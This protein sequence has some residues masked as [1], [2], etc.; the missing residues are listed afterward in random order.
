[1]NRRTL[2]VIG[3]TATIT[4]LASAAVQG[5]AFAARPDKTD[6]QDTVS[7][8][9]MVDDRPTALSTKR[10]EMKKRAMELVAKGERNVENRGGSKSVR[11][12]PGQWVEYETQKTGQ[13]LSFL[14]DFNKAKGDDGEA[15]PVHGNIPKPDRTPGDSTYDNS[16][17]W[18]DSFDRQH[19]LDMFFNGMPEQNGESFHDAYEELSS[20]RYNI[21][22][23]VSDWVTVPH[24]EAYYGT[25]EN[26]QNMTEFIS[27]AAAAWLADA[28]SKG[29]DPQEYLAQFDKW[30]RYDADGD[31]DFD[32]PDGYIDHFQAIHA[33]EGEEAGAPV[34]AIWS[35]RWA[36][37][38]SGDVGPA[39][40][41]LGGIE[42]GDTGFWIRDYTTE[43]ENGG[44]GVFAHEFGHDLGLPDLYDTSGGDNGT[45]F[46]TLMSSGSWMNHGGDSIGTTPNHMGAWEKWFLGWLDYDVAFAGES[47]THEI[48]PA[49][50]ATKKPQALIT[51]LP[52]H[53]VVTE[54]GPAIEGNNYFY[55]G[56]GDDRTATMT[57][58]TFTVPDNGQLT[59]KVNYSIEADWDYAYAEVSTDGETFTPLDTNLSTE[60][61]P[62]NQNDGHGITGS[63]HGEWVDLVADMAQYAGQDVQLRFRM[64]NDAGYNEMGLKVDQI[65]VGDALT[66]GAEDGA[67][68][69][70]M[71]K[72]VV[73]EDGRTEASYAGY[74]IA[75]SRH[76]IGYDAT[77]GQGAYNFG[78]GGTQPNR[79]ER[80]PYQDGLLISYWNTEYADNNTAQHP[81]GG[82]VLPVDARPAAL[83]WDDPSSTVARSR[84]QSFDV[85][86]GTQRTD[87]I[88]LHR[89]YGV[90]TNGDEEADEIRMSNLHVG[91]QPAVRVFDDSDPMAY[92]DQD[93]PQG[94]VIVQGTGTTITVVDE[95][96]NNGMMTL[97]VN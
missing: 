84:I 62:N 12:A 87:E 8:K 75:E 22:G 27:D 57:S 37:N 74:Y 49:E 65:A 29:L 89:E 71:D 2:G 59:A 60:T 88:S 58:P 24:N 64:F 14:V 90:D 1:V 26:N 5:T 92:Y 86:F 11:I 46:W 44:L 68:D 32:E 54:L 40:A 66:E 4:L 25:E 3:G 38:P 51:I 7:A 47:S 52:K 35:H 48:G 96:H 15:G 42:I 13:I 63:S 82:L 19:Y 94:S 31:G 10:R 18:V 83:R 23:D 91:S 53:E 72:F 28:E 21:A 69:W 70:T 30:D 79:V 17:Y 97:E 41:K 20:G 77:L 34:S 6:P 78:W 9:R 80:F 45:G 95:N 56:R 61:S 55:S 85:T 76:Y 67:P 81:G 93:N 50:H 43:P 36:V 33:G 16:T 39:D 73:V